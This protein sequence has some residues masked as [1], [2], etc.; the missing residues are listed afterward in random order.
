MH[1]HHTPPAPPSRVAPRLRSRRPRDPMPHPRVR[2][3]VIFS[4]SVP[5][6][7]TSHDSRN[8]PQSSSRSV[9]P[10][11]TPHSSLARSVAAR[12]R[13][14][15]AVRTRRD[16]RR[17]RALGA[18]RSGARARAGDRGRISST[19][20]GSRRVDRASRAVAKT[21]RARAREKDHREGWDGRR[22]D[23]GW[24]RDV[25]REGRRRARVERS[26]RARRG[27]TRER[28]AD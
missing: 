6:P 15:I 21:A 16:R 1:V 12:E 4:E 7:T 11:S 25:E 17:A 20:R 23:R 13:S 14:L 3:H 19:R 28:I 26:G 5:P 10:R 9:A 27:A 22:D 18:S 8:A 2:C 24:R